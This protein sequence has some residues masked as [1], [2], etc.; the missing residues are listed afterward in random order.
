MQYEIDIPSLFAEDHSIYRDI[1]GGEL[2]KQGK[3]LWRFRCNEEELAE[4]LNDA[5]F[6]SDREHWKMGMGSEEYAELLPII[7]SAERTVKRLKEI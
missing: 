7:K 6:Y 1:W 5:E 2:L 4:W 3:N